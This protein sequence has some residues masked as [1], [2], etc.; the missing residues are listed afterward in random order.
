M[1]TL[2]TGGIRSGKSRCAEELLAGSAEVTYIAPGPHW[3]DDHEWRARVAAHRIRRPA[4]WQTI[5]DRDLAG[6]LTRVTGPALI[7][8]LNTWL[9][10]QLDDLDGWATTGWEAELGD[11]IDAAVAAWDASPH[12]LVAVTNEVGLG[13]VSEHR[14]GRVFADWLGLLNQRIA[15]VCDEVILVVA[16]RRLRL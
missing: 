4:H 9:T 5:E 7:D 2:V 15:D 16:G 1:K 13:L 14:S 3:P 8:C 12:R 10:G 11:R 6:V